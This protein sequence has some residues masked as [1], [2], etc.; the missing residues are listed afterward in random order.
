MTI[1]LTDPANQLALEILDDETLGE[2]IQFRR[3]TTKYHISQGNKVQ[4]IMHNAVLSALVELQERRKS[5]V[6]SA[7]QPS[8]MSGIMPDYEGVAM[9][10]REC[11]MAG[12]EAGLAEARKS[13]VIPDGWIPVSERM[14]EDGDIVLVVDDGY[15]VCEAQYREG[16]FYSEVR[17]RDE[18]FETTCRD[19]CHWQPLPNPPKDDL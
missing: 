8:R 16:D 1:N 12:K 11:Y 13:P 10:Q 19:V 17:G 9:T 15:F 18:F 2:L 4:A 3:E 7:P 6:S 14:P 5:D